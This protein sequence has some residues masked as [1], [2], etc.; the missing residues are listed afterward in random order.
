M[1][2]SDCVILINCFHSYIFRWPWDCYGLIARIRKALETS[3]SITVHFTPRKL[4]GTAD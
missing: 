4:N 1:V 2:F 3:P